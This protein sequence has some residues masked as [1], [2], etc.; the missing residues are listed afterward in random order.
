MLPNCHLKYIKQP[1]N[2]H[3]FLSLK[4]KTLQLN[5]SHFLKHGEAINP[6][7]LEYKNQKKEVGF[8]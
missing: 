8:E 1:K 6:R 2:K 3:S 5:N 7:S 4:N